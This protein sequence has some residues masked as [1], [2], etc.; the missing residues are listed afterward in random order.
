MLLS[1][2]PPDKLQQQL[3]GD[4]TENWTSIQKDE[5]QMERQI[6]KIYRTVRRIHVKSWRTDETQKVNTKIFVPM[7]VR[8]QF[9][10]IPRCTG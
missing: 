4:A 10:F 8:R 6:K 2:L 9:R 5:V 3:N 7:H 1:I